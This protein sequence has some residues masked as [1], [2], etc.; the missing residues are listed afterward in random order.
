MDEY[1]N[2]FQNLFAFVDS[3]VLYEFVM[4]SQFLEGLTLRYKGQ[5]QVQRLKTLR[6]IVDS[7]RM[8]E[9]NIK[10]A[11]TTREIKNKEKYNEI[12]QRKKAYRE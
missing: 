3:V 10:E 6:D 2:K 11:Q 8:V 7:T 9:I 4:A 1:E 5:I 12:G